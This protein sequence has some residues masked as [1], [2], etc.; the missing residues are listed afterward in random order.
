MW[1][2]IIIITYDSAQEVAKQHT[3]ADHGE[4]QHVVEAE[5]GAEEATTAK[6]A[7][8]FT[9]RKQVRADRMITAAKARAR[10]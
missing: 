7:V 5:A 9:Y 2:N 3:V 6:D 10:G 8:T 1:K 4:V